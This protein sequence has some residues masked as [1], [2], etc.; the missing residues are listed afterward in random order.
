MALAVAG[1]QSLDSL[2]RLV[3]ASFSS[4]PTGPNP[5]PNPKSYPNPNPDPNPNPNP[6]PNPHLT[7]ACLGNVLPMERGKTRPGLTPEGLREL[8]YDSVAAPDTD[9]IVVY[10]RFQA[11][12]R[13]QT[14]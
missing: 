7:K 12:R 2:Q 10:M 13:A 1:P 6:N 9:E 11:V 4:L 3:L 5:D 8:G 14:G